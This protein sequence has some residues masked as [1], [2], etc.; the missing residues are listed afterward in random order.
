MTFKNIPS[1]GFVNENLHLLY[2]ELK[3]FPKFCQ[4]L[5]IY[6]KSYPQGY[7]QG[8]PQATL[9]ILIRKIELSTENAL[10]NNK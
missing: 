6:G 1:V 4:K 2:N 3:N 8:Y 7:P 9:L 5:K 10:P